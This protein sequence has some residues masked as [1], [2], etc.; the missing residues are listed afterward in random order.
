MLAFWTT[1]GGN[2]T[3]EITLLNSAPDFTSVDQFFVGYYRDGILIYEP[4][5]PVYPDSSLVTVGSNATA[6]RGLRMRNN[7]PSAVTCTIYRFESDEWVEDS[8]TVVPNDNTLT[9][10]RS[11][12]YEFPIRVEI[13]P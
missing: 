11:A 5:M 9:T 8:Q 2:Y 1:F 7:G 4:S 13:T 12:N 6:D 3:Q 10:Q